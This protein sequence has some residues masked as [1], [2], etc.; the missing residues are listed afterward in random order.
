MTYTPGPWKIHFYEDPNK[1]P[2]TVVPDEGKPSWEF[3]NINI[4]AASECQNDETILATVSGM[5]APGG[6]PY[7]ENWDEVRANARLIAAA[8]DLLA[9]LEEIVAATEQWNASM[10]AVI[11][12][13]PNTSIDLANAWDA[14]AAARGE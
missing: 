6:F 3:L 14:I 7:V 5:T 10:E 1:G 9:A 12:R 2:S 11:G 13:Q 8:P 4:A